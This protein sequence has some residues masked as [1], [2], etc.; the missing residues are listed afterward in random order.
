MNKIQM[1][2]MYNIKIEDKIK[3]VIATISNRYY[4]DYILHTEVVI[5]LDYIF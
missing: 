3:C 1:I 2:S 4:V 5:I